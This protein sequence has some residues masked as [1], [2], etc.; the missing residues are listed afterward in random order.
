M[1]LSSRISDLEKNRPGRRVHELFCEPEDYRAIGITDFS[2][3]VTED[4]WKRAQ[5]HAI[6][7]FKRE[8]PEEAGPY[9]EFIF[10]VFDPNP[11]V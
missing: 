4:D 8:H 9:D 11:D 3:G 7:R 1:S 5:K 10:P 6:A 2:H